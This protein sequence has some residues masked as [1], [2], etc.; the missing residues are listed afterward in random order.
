MPSIEDFPKPASSL[1][2]SVQGFLTFITK[3]Q[4]LDSEVSPYAPFK[5]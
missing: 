3:A 5:I 1:F 4:F 2:K